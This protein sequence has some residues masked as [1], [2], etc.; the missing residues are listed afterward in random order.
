[1]ITKFKITDLPEESEL[2]KQIY[3]ITANLAGDAFSERD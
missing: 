1:M 3:R 2:S